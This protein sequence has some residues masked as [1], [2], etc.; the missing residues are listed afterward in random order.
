MKV[1]ALEKHS[2]RPDWALIPKFLVLG[3]TSLLA[4][5]SLVV[6]MAAVQ[7]MCMKYGARD[8]IFGQPE[9]AQIPRCSAQQMKA[10]IMR[11]SP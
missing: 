4:Q 7:N 11:T 1:V 8:P 10:L 9:Y 2:F 3:L 6:S 5:I